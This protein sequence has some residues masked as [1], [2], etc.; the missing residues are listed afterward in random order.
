[1][2]IRAGYEIAFECY[3]EVPMLLLLSVHPSRQKDLL[4]ERRINLSPLVPARQGL[5]P[6]GNVRVLV[7]CGAPKYARF[8]IFLRS[9]RPCR[10]P[11]QLWIAPIDPFEHVRHLRRRDRHRIT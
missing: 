2:I 10:P 11:R 9:T 7:I 6:F 8:H 5:D 4:T 1:V 3:Q